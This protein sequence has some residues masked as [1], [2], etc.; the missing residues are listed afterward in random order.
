M[1][2]KRQKKNEENFNMH[3]VGPLF[4][5]SSKACRGGSQDQAVVA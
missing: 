2:G 5:G 4:L 3:L 1:D